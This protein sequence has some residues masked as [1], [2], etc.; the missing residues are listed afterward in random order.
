ML[1]CHVYIGDV[2][3]GSKTPSERGAPGD[4]S[5]G[6]FVVRSRAGRGGD[7]GS[8]HG[9]ARGLW[10]RDRRN[11]GNHNGIRIRTDHPCASP[12]VGGCHLFPPPSLTKWPFPL[13]RIFVRSMATTPVTT[14]SQ[15]WAV[16]RPHRPAPDASDPR[17][18]YQRSLPCADAV[19]GP[20]PCL[21][22]FHAR[23]ILVEQCSLQ[24]G[25][26]FRPRECFE[27]PIFV[28]SKE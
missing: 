6:P 20:G 15:A 27:V 23:P 22:P 11:R 16:V 18:R 13:P 7:A 12:L 9:G 25:Q 4:P 21:C 5:A 17:A 3:S 8:L 2:S 28:P 26:A 19:A 14:Q 24:D 10:S 1:L